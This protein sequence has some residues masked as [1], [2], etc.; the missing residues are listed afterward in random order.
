MLK[1][2]HPDGSSA[3]SRSEIAGEGGDRA[4]G[5]CSQGLLSRGRGLRGAGCRHR[6]GSAARDAAA[7]SRLRP[8]LSCASPRHS[9]SSGIP[10]SCSPVPRTPLSPFSTPIN[11]EEPNRSF[12]GQCVTAV[13]AETDTAGMRTASGFKSSNAALSPL[14]TKSTVMPSARDVEQGGSFYSRG[15]GHLPM[16]LVSW[17]PD[18]Q[19]FCP[20]E[21]DPEPVRALWVSVWSILN[22]KQKTCK[23]PLWKAKFWKERSEKN[24]SGKGSSAV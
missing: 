23:K 20:L 8:G 10:G 15:Q 5:R 18:A 3:L 1:T 22:F 16:I 24:N 9:R 19:G 17:V 6:P 13:T 14:V 12:P 7:L 21:W 11:S 2:L 4:W